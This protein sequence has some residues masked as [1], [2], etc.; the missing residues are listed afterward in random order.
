MWSATCKELETKKVNFVF[1]KTSY[2]EAQ[3]EALYNT[4]FSKM[5][6]AQTSTRRRK[7]ENRNNILFL[8]IQPNEWKRAF[9]WVSYTL[10]NE[11]ETK[12]TYLNLKFAFG[13]YRKR[14]NLH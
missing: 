8:L 2:R 5:K 14:K 7:K 12:R 10:L 6:D 9:R 13:G 11:F 4:E 1:T 3:V